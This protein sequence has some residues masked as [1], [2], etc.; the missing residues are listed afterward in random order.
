MTLGLTIYGLKVK[1]LDA[2]PS[3]T[4]AVHLVIPIEHQALNDIVAGF[5]ETL[6]A[7]LP[8]KVSY[9]VHNAQGDANLQ[10]SIFQQLAQEK[11]ALVV[12]VTTTTTQLAL[13]LIKDKPILSLAAMYREADRT[14]HQ[15]TGV[16]DEIEPTQFVSFLKAIHTDS[17]RV[18][19]IYSADDRRVKE[20]TEL[21]GLLKAQQIPVKRL[22][23]QTLNDLYTISHSLPQD[24]GSVV[25]FKD[26]LVASGVTVLKKV[27]DDKKIL[28]ITSDEGTIKK[29]ASLGFGVTEKDIGIE[30]GKLAVKIL[31]G[32]PIQTIPIQHLSDLKIFVNVQFLEKNETLKPLLEKISTQ[33]HY[34]LVL[35]QT[36]TSK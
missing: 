16:L 27:C 3:E 4:L 34:R 19:V 1:F 25:M 33:H 7:Q 10:R 21:E 31:T 8:G 36:E 6:S 13:K 24:T 12:P 9:K 28:L 15:I 2:H 18:V 22:M 35:I 23:I 26:N 5:E 29:G 14:G 32:T 30:G 20:A 17:S 11:A